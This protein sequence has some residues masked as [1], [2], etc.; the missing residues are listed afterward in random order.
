[1]QRQ[2]Q[3]PLDST[4][5]FSALRKADAESG[6]IGTDHLHALLSLAQVARV[7]LSTGRA[8]NL[9]GIGLLTPHYSGATVTVK[10]TL[11]P[12]LKAALEHLHATL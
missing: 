2:D 7:T 3:S 4:E 5:L 11:S 6:V 9:P 10:L 8:I 12:T 1:M